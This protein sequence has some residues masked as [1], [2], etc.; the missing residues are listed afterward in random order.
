[1]RGRSGFH[2]RLLGPRPTG[3]GRFDLARE[4]CCAL[5]RNSA[6]PV[7]RYLLS[8]HILG[9]SLLALVS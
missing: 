9:I 7:G 3:A 8:P 2:V 5:R 4:S 6:L 1:M